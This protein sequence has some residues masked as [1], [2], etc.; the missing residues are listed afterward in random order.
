MGHGPVRS[1]ATGQLITC[2]FNDCYQLGTSRYEHRERIGVDL[3]RM[4]RYRIYLFCSERHRELWR[5][6]HVS[7]GNLPTGLR[8]MIT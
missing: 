7:L 3:M 4:P 1:G 6:S 5:H 2:C 8:G